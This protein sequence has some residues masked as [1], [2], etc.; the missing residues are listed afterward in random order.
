MVDQERGGLAVSLPT[1]PVRAEPQRG[2]PTGPTTTV[3]MALSAA[4]SPRQVDGGDVPVGAE[5]EQSGFWDDD[6][7]DQGLTRRPQIQ[8]AM[9]ASTV[10][11]ALGRAARK[12]KQDQEQE[13]TAAAR[14]FE[15]GTGSEQSPPP[16]EGGRSGKRR[17]GKKRSG[18]AEVE[19]FPAP[20]AELTEIG[21]EERER[22][23]LLSVFVFW[24][25]ALVLLVLAAVVV[26]AVR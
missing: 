7:L 6:D 1:G 19:Q 8:T 24:A 12:R 13:A 23:R 20:D 17:S 2:R 9:P 10:V 14:R 15:Q 25:P 22:H 18:K 11:P 3:T 4:V 16:V 21:T 5:I 26:W